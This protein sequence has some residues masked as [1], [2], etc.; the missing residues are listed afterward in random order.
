[1]SNELE[2]RFTTYLNKTLKGYSNKQKIKYQKESIIKNSLSDS[3]IRKISFKNYLLNN[4]ELEDID[5]NINHLENIF[6]NE[7]YCKAMKKVSLKQR[8]VLYLLFVEEYNTK[9]VAKYFQTTTDNINK[10]KRKAIKNFKKNLEE[11]KYG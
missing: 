5:V 1:M 7:K 10:I 9:E 4:N 11:L 8:Q 3:D 6:H 2:K